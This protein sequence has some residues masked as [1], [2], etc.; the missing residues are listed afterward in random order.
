MGTCK[1][2]VHHVLDAVVYLSQTNSPHDSYARLYRN[3]GNFTPRCFHATLQF[4]L[5]RPEDARLTM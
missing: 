4:L 2:W 3:T 5:R 1:T